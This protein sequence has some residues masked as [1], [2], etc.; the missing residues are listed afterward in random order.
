MERGAE[1][2]KGVVRRKESE[3]D[4]NSS[5][6]G[7]KAAIPQTDLRWS[8]STFLQRIIWALTL[9]AVLWPKVAQAGAS[10]WSYFVP[11]ELNIKAVLERLRWDVFRKGNYYKLRREQKAKSPDQALLLND[12][13]GTHSIIDIQKVAPFPSSSCEFGTVCPLSAA[14][15][16]ELFGTEKPSR[17]Q[18]DAL[19]QD[20]RLLSHFQRWSGVYVVVYEGST[21]KWLY[22]AGYSG[23]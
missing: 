21:P 1:Q 14:A 17:A 6:H 10:G 12:T 9:L 23:D 15:L 11:Y 7:A 13:E 22:F 3:N 5:L 8:Y 19:A 2:E 16:V 18:V 20:N 4:M